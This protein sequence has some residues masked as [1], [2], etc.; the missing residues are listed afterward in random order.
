VV[1]ER[2]SAQNLKYLDIARAE[3]GTLSFGGEPL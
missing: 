1:D 2:Q 3:G